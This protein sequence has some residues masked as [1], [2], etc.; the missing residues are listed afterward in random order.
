MDMAEITPDAVKL[1]KL[2]Q[3][4]IIV[5]DVNEVARQ[6]WNVLGIGPHMM[7]NV[8]PT[9]GYVM[10]YREKPVKYKFIASF[11]QVGPVEI[12]L[13]QNVEGQTLYKDYLAEHDEGANH[14][15]FLVDNVKVVQAFK[16][17]MSRRGFPALMS[18]HFKDVVGYVYA[19]TTEQLK[20]VW[21]AVKLPEG[22]FG[23][24][25]VFFPSDKK[26]IS[27]SKVKV[28]AIATVGIVVD[29]LEETVENYRNILGVE[30]WQIFEPASRP[31]HDVVYRGKK[32]IPDWRVAR[33]KIGQAQI[34][35]VQPIAPGS[36]YGEYLQKHGP[37]I[38]NLQFLTDDIERTNMLMKEAGF[39]VLMGGK[40]ADG[41]FSFYNTQGSLK[42]IWVAFQPPSLH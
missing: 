37:G 30:G 12:E 40:Y 24:P 22:P 20:T 13:L 41:G 4:G 32:I 16:R 28:D 14:L 17:I 33:T 10:T 3:V 25:P 21:E 7:V 39:G 42:I 11:C 18:G 15:Q 2:N 6:Y 26:M 35:L 38:H 34:E 5:R 19:D 9:P 8:E 27:K 1:K 23:A 29:S 31:F 36:L